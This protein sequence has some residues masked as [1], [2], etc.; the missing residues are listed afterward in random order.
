MYLRI[1]VLNWKALSCRAGTQ[2][3]KRTAVK[4][5]P[6]FLFR[7]RGGQLWFSILSLLELG[8]ILESNVCHSCLLWLLI[9]GNEGMIRADAVFVLCFPWRKTPGKHFVF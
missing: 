4:A 3:C 5:K 7:P 6:G 9:P 8:I 1:L 2:D